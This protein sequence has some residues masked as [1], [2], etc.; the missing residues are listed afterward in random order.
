M[1]TEIRS[2]YKELLLVSWKNHLLCLPFHSLPFLPRLLGILSS[3]S[4]L[5]VVLLSLF[6]SLATL[7]LHCCMGFLWL[8][9][10]RLFFSCSAQASHSN[11]A[12][13]VAEHWFLECVGSIVVAHG[14]SC[15]MTYGF[16][17][18]RP[19]IKPVSLALADGF[20]TTGPQESLL[21]SLFFFFLV[22]CFKYFWCYFDFYN[23]DKNY[24][25]HRNKYL[26]LEIILHW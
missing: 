22:S 6:Y 1:L 21:L 13:L 16:L 20:L 12:S 10:W 23:S 9:K 7:A 5:I 24:K 11:V 25:L 19:G 17:F 15:P 14:F 26:A 3:I 8:Q 2:F 4:D 18:S